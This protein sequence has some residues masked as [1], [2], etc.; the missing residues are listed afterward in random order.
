MIMHIK[1]NADRIKIIAI[2]LLFINGNYKTYF[3][4]NQRFVQNIFERFLY[5]SRTLEKKMKYGAYIAR[6]YHSGLPNVLMS[7]TK[8]CK[9]IFIIKGSQRLYPSFLMLYNSAQCY[10]FQP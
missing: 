2:L 1:L 7:E 6:H 3:Y 8:A 10:V 9:F 5:N 4:K